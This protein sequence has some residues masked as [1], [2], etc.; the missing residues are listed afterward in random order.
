M[1]PAFRARTSVADTNPRN[2]SVRPEFSARRGKQHPGRV[3]SPFNFG[4]RAESDPIRL[5]QT[6][7]NKRLSDLESKMLEVEYQR[8]TPRLYFLPQVAHFV[9]R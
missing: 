4:I 7:A 9:C 1:R 8:E 2:F 3:R 5:N 6:Y